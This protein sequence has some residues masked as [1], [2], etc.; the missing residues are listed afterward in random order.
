MTYFIG[1]ANWCL[2]YRIASTATVLDDY[3]AVVKSSN[4]VTLGFLY[5]LSYLF[6]FM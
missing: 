1:V 3:Q 6:T 5:A 4:N 2:C